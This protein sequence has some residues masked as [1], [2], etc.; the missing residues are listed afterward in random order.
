[1][2]PDP[3]DPF[4]PTLGRRRFLQVG[5]A[6][7][8]LCTI[9]GEKVAVAQRGDAAKADAAAARVPRPKAVSAAAA[10]EPTESQ[11]YVTP[12]PQPGGRAV[13]YWIQ[14]TQARWTIVPSKRD[15]WHGV[16]VPG[17]STFTATVYQQMTDGFA[18]ALGPAAM[19]GPTL[20]AEVGDTLVVHVRNG[21]TGDRKQAITM[22]PHG[23]KYNPEYDGAYMGAYTRAGGFVA[24]G[25]EFTY[26][27]EC[28]P[29]SAGAW[30]YHDHGPN[31]T[32]NTFR[33]LFGA[34]VITEPGA[35]VPDVS[36]TLMLHSLIPP[37]T[38]LPR[39][40]QCINGRAYAGNTPTL[41]AKAGQ[42]VA[43]HVFGADSNFHDFHMHGHRWRDTG[44]APTDTATVGPGET[45][46]ARFTEDNPGRW[47][48]HCH[49]FSH[50]DEGM[51]GWYEVDA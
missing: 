20:H 18:A 48:Y 24:P 44:G 31:H 10:K 15:D 47:L 7:A 4:D 37:I 39:A 30:P 49:V 42:D 25:E 8:F 34:L 22:H 32:L 19:P 38:G 11:T 14:A 16:A 28:V 46:T 40:F 29:G 43:I 3:L 2:T 5:A 13:E 27:W 12:S 6:G 21:L 35:K 23:V 45:M 33:G 1:M 9:G 17:A 36:Y 50:Q 26:R 41:R 51:A